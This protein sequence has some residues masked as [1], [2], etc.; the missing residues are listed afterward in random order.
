MVTLLCE[1]GIVCCTV[2]WH[3]SLAG[4]FQNL[5]LDIHI[6]LPF[7]PSVVFFLTFVFLYF[8]IGTEINLLPA[9]FFFWSEI[10]SRTIN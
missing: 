4:Y 2:K 5:L 6:T 9:T 3:V 10:I 8:Q 7:R 1:D